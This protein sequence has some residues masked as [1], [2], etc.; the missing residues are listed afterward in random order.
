VSENEWIIKEERFV[1]VAVNEVNCEIIEDFGAIF[2]CADNRWA[3]VCFNNRVPIPGAIFFYLP[4]APLVESSIG[5]VASLVH[6]LR[7]KVIPV[8]L[9]FSSCS[10]FVAG[11]LKEL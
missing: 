11:A 6:V 3:I 1:L 4:K 8:E 9:P 2:A 10:G 7:E 5:G